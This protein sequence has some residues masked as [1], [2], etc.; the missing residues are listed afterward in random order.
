MLKEFRDFIAR[1]NVIDMAIGIIMGASFTTIVKSMV[2]DIIMPIIGVFTNGVDFSKLYLNLS[3]KEFES[4]AAA[5]AAGAAT[6]NYGMFIN[7]CITF[8]I[9]S[10]V[11]FMMLKSV[12]RLM[13]KKAAE[14]IAQPASAPADIQLLTEIRDLLARK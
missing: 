10:F 4:L 5:K 11:V 12:N 14:E 9:V 7:A 6:I 8:M 13:K 2:D 3:G 1:G